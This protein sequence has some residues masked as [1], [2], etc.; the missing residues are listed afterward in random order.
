MKRNHGFTLIELLVA[1][2][3]IGILA[4]IL[5]PTLAR[6]STR[7]AAREAARRRLINLNEPRQLAGRRPILIAHRGGIVGPGSP[8]CSRNAIVR[9]SL[10]GYDMVELDIQSSKD[11]QPI[12]FHDR[13]LRP[14]CEVD[15]SV[16]DYGADVLQAMVFVE[17]GEAVLHLSDALALC[18]QE[19]L[20]V[21][22]D[23]KAKGSEG[24]YRRILGLLERFELT[25]ATMCINGEPAI[26]KHLGKH[27]MLR[28]TDRRA[29]DLSGLFWFGLANE[30][31][32]DKAHDLQARG[33][34]VIPAIN[35]FRYDAATHREDARADAKRLLEAGVDGF[36]I[37]SVYQDDFGLGE[38]LPSAMDEQ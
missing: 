15:G 27:I 8:E 18:A 28:A 34:L 17:N 20:G 36:Q 32:A 1:I 6:A 19:R 38:A 29:T 7:E 11:G 3:I 13:K 10:A 12:V 16:A 22:L 9:A 4:L 35:T 14:S 30:L 24:F 37:D 21:M 33:A 25:H 23:I 5:L 26:R 2:A 31:T